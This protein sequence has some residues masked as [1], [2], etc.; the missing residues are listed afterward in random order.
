MLRREFIS[1]SAAFA[2][3]SGVAAAQTPAGLTLLHAASAPD[4]DVLGALWAQDSGIF[5][6]FGLDVRLQPMN[7]G[8]AVGAAVIG[9]AIEMGKSS[10]ISLITAHT[11]GIPFVCVAPAGVYSSKAPVVGM[12]VKKGSPIKT[13]RDLNGKTLS[14]PSLN[15]Q[16]SIAI[17]AWMDQHGGDSTSVKFLELPNSSVPQAIDDGRID[18][19]S[20]ANPILSEALD[21]GKVQVIG[22]T[23][24]AIAPTFIQACYFVTADYANKNRDVVERFAKAIAESGAYC[25][26]HH[27]A[28]VQILSDFTKVAPQTIRAMTRTTIGTTL[29]PRLIQPVIDS[30]AKYKAIPSSFDAREMIAPFL[31]S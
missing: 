26:A 22:R 20:I 23:F 28:T 25:N 9:G 12:L 27:D 15:D 13:A 11:K 10:L 18:A 24:D 31:R 29:D 8:S 4:E 16:Y 30:A 6:R 1:T 2:L 21:S 7:S 14:V 3:T 17:R 19:A 5:R